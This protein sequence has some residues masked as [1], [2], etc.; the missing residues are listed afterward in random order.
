MKS[1]FSFMESIDKDLYNLLVDV[2]RC[3][4]ID[5]YE[6]AYKLRSFWEAFCGYVFSK[7]DIYD[8]LESYLG[9]SPDLSSSMAFLTEAAKTGSEFIPEKV[10]SLQD[11]MKR[12]NSERVA[13]NLEP[14]KLFRDRQILKS[15]SRDGKTL[16]RYL[17]QE[18]KTHFHKLWLMVFFRE[19]GNAATHKEKAKAVAKNS[20]PQ[21][22]VNYLQTIDY[23]QKL[24]E[25]LTAYFGI[26]GL[27]Y[28]ENVILFD[29][30]EVTKVNNSPSDKYRSLCCKECEAFYSPTT[31]VVSKK[32]P[33][34]IRFFNKNDLDKTSAVRSASAH[35][36]LD[37]V[38]YLGKGLKHVDELSS[39]ESSSQ[40]YIVA[41]VFKHEP[42]ALSNELLKTTDLATRLEWCKD[43]SKVMERLHSKS[44]E[45]IKICHRLLSPTCIYITKDSDTNTLVASLTKL[46]F[47]KLVRQDAP[48]VYLKTMKAVEKI[49]QASDQEYKYIA[50]ELIALTESDGNND[51]NANVDEVFWEKVDIYA[52]GMLISDILCADISAFPHTEEELK[53]AGVSANIIGIIKKCRLTAKERP[54]ASE[55]HSVF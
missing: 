37:D 4:Y 54:N 31:G 9:A 6:P 45:K 29:K 36:L 7:Y 13:R 42:A 8:K 39:Y 55:I 21:F 25:F 10:K 34:I 47:A 5:K 33:A 48:T 27:K 49:G 12:L 20:K 44:E 32:Y 24:H 11:F 28:N 2:E 19:Y 52:L 43:I 40:F 17:D 53:N 18:Q 35:S 1:N 23:L 50:P 51:I 22:D 46:S 3:L 14:V 15:F 30:Y 38:S 16:P 41:Y 26:T